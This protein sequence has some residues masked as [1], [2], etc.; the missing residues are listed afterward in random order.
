MPYLSPVSEGFPLKDLFH[1]SPYNFLHSSIKNSL[2]AGHDPSS[3]QRFL[4]DQNPT[5]ST[6]SEIQALPSSLFY[7]VHVPCGGSQIRSQFPVSHGLPSARSLCPTAPLHLSFP[8]HFLSLL[9]PLSFDNPY[10]SSSGFLC[11][12]WPVDSWSMRQMRQMRQRTDESTPRCFAQCS[13]SVSSLLDF[14]KV[15]KNYIAPRTSLFC[16]IC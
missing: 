15:Q 9:P 2:H 12:D 13:E 16:Q 8:L 4:S 10:A 11:A 14:L 1:Y 7:F 6:N 3:V 5:Q